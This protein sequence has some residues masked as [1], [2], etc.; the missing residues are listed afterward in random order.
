M[1]LD[2]RYLMSI[3]GQFTWIQLTRYVTVLIRNLPIAGLFDADVPNPPPKGS[4]LK[5]S[6]CSKS[7]M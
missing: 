5:G 3:Q 4:S 6:A 7:K 1:I 2:V